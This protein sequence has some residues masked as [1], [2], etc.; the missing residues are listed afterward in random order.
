MP[1][2]LVLP[3]LEIPTWMDDVRPKSA[4][5]ARDVRVFFKLASLSMLDKLIDRGDFPPPDFRAGPQHK[6]RMWFISTIK[7]VV[8]HG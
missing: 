3:K 6:H 4:M 5:S 7:K 2:R 1:K 8:K